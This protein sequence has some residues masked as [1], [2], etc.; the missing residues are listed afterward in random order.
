MHQGV[1]RALG[2]RLLRDIRRIDGE[3]SGFHEGRDLAK[4]DGRNPR[5]AA[6]T[7]DGRDSRTEG[8]GPARPRAGQEGGNHTGAFGFSERGGDNLLAKGNLAGNPFYFITH[9]PHRGLIQLDLTVALVMLAVVVLFAL[10]AILLRVLDGRGFL[11]SVAVGYS[12]IVGGGLGWF[13]I[14]AVFFTLGVAFTLYKYDYK[15]RIGAAEAKGGARNWPNIL[16]NGGAASIFA[17]AELFSG[18]LLFAALFV[19]SMAA[20][21]SDTVSTELGLLSKFKPRLLI[22]PRSPVQPGTSGGVTPLG[23]VGAFFASLVIGVMAYLLGVLPGLLAP[24][25]AGLAGG[26]VGSVADSFYGAT[27]QRKGFCV[28]C[29]KPVENLTHCGGEPTRRTRRVPFLASNSANL[30]GSVTGALASLISILL[31]MGH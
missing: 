7:E 10:A 8:A 6:E 27:I 11:A 22:R 2:I 3:S 16:A 20:A 30:L 26:L 18:G 14:V 4:P 28:V 15:K 17:L 29:G 23:F 5:L 9:S 1:L 25:V 24:L 19:G 21:A 12:I 13:I 31:L